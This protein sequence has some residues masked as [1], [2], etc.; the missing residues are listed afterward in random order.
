MPVPDTDPG[1]INSYIHRYHVLN[2]SS[3]CSID[4]VH[5]MPVPDTDPGVNNSN[6]YTMCSIYLLPILHLELNYAAPLEAFLGIVFPI[7]CTLYM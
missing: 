2:I 1:V 7:H 6:I 5:N 4:T 3:S